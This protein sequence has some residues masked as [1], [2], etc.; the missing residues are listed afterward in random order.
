MKYLN[1]LAYI[2][3]FL[4][5]VMLVS[6]FDANINNNNTAK[7]NNNMIYTG[8]AKLSSAPKSTYIVFIQG[9]GSKCNGTRY[10]NIGFSYI[11]S[12]LTAYGFQYR[13]RRFLQYSYTGGEVKAGK[14]FP[15]KYGPEDT[16]QPI[17]ISVKYLND[18]IGE[19]SAAHPNARFII[20]G[21][22]LGGVIAY[23]FISKYKENNSRSIK[24]VVT[25]NA[26]L[27]GCIYRVPNIVLNTL[28]NKGSV[29]GSTAVR[30]LIIQNEFR[31][32]LES[33]RRQVAQRLQ[34]KVYVWLHSLP[35]RT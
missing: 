1:K 25:L 7:I 27:T 5:A 15:N 26:P 33:M 16:G 3:V 11:R 2:L 21:H 32:E 18:L 9:L 24:G 13:D 19:F 6:A 30:E 23:D 8:N 14:W 29:W 31:V 35:S 28:E 17:E 12:K 4:I 34:K 20:V 22:S 10:S